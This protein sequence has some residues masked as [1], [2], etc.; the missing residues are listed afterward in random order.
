MKFKGVELNGTYKIICYAISFVVYDEKG[1][2]IYKED[3]SGKWK[4]DEKGNLIYFEDNT[5]YWER[6]E[7]D[8]KGNI[9]YFENSDGYWEKSE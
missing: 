7:Y 3:S 5:G 6:R 2:K 9:I 4:Y 8:E 1:N